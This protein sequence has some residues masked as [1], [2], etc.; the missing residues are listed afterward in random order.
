MA[1][2]SDP[3]DIDDT[4]LEIVADQSLATDTYSIQNTGNHT[5]FARLSDAAIADLDTIT[6]GHYIYPKAWFTLEVEGTNDFCYLFCAPDSESTIL[7]T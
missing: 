2:T 3:I 6:T 1:T 5:V 4:P 7:I